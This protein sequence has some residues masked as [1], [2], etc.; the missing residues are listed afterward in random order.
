[1]AI[2][3]PNK[4]EGIEMKTSDVRSMFFPKCLLQFFNEI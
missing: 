1:M 4:L 3:K 2:T